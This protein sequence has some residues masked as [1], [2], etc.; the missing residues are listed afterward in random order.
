[1]EQTMNIMPQ[2]YDEDDLKITGKILFYT[3]NLWVGLYILKA[4]FLS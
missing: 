2:D 4:V 3:I 1:M